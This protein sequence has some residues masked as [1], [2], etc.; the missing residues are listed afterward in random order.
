[1]SIRDLGYRPYD[2][3]RHPAEQNAWV[4]LRHSLGRAWRSWI[5]KLTLLFSWIP[6]MGFIL[7]TRAAS[8]VQSQVGGEA[9]FDANPWLDWL[10]H[11]QWLSAAFVVALT[12]GAGAIAYDLNHNA[13]AYF[14][15]KPVTA[16][17]YLIGRMGAVVLLCL[18]VTL[19]PVG[20]F[21]AAMLALGSGD[22]VSNLVSLLRATAGAVTISVMMGVCSVG[23]SALNRS[24]A[25][26]FSAWVLTFFVPWG[27]AVLV[28]LV[29]DWPWLRL[30]A[31]PLLVS[32]LVDAVCAQ[33]EAEEVVRWYHSAPVAI[34]LVAGAIAIAYRRIRN[35]EVVA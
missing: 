16:A 33:T 10:L 8:L 9:E 2:G 24:R 19:M 32:D 17:Q 7:G 13:F 31:F 6:V 15:S 18:F 29:S 23:F 4:I 28:E 26:T 30:L 12:A 34:A 22:P 25:F 27:L 35:V 20:L 5:I 3:E 11:T 1:M 21:S 14:F